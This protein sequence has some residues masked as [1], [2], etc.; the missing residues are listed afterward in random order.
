MNTYFDQTKIKWLQL[1]R[2]QGIGPIKFWNLLKKYE[3]IERAIETL[4]D[5][6]PYAKAEAELYE[7][8]KRGYHLIAAYEENYPSR[9]KRLNDFPPLISVAGNIDSLG[10]PAIAIVGARNASLGGRKLS[11]H[12]AKGLG[13][14]GWVIVSG[15]ARGIDEA[16]HKG[17][18]K[19]KTIAVLA[20]GVDH[21]YP[22]EHESLYKEILEDGAIISEMPLGTSPSASLF[23][24]RNRLIAALSQGI[25]I[26]EAAYKSGSLI[27]AEYALDLGIDVFAV[28]GSPL[29]PRCQG[30]NHLLKQGALLVQ[31]AS[32][33]LEVIGISDHP[34]TNATDTTPAEYT[35]S[36]LIKPSD[37]KKQILEDLTTTPIPIEIFLENYNYPPGEL[38]SLLAEL[39]LQGL[40]IRHPGNCVSLVL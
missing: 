4:K 30:C 35:P 6:Y 8:Q 39:E 23:P 3:D 11:F 21:I 13:E 15:L 17:S 14:K 28:P 19:T 12:F 25:V 31:S 33:I 1:I 7:H 5:P 36:I 37:I 18:L 9:L 34:Q 32:D 26:V 29:D 22:P 20:G 10:K 40:L 2:T 24:R 38:M 16:A 27:T